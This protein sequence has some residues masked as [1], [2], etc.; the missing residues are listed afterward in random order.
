MRLFI[1]KNNVIVGYE[2]E[3]NSTEGIEYLNPLPDDFYSKFKSKFYMLADG[4]IV[5]NPNYVAPKPPVI[6]PSNQDK[7]NAQIMLNQAKQKE[8]QDKFNA[9]TLLQLAKLGGNK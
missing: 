7:I 5:E 4:V 6:G 8:E 9:Q 3:G 1:D 2:I